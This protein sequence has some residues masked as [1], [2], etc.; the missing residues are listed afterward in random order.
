MKWRTALLVLIRSNLLVV[1]LFAYIVGNNHHLMVSLMDVLAT[2]HK[3]KVRKTP[4]SFIILS[5]DLAI[6]L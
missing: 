3:S 5:K 1:F 2:H 6:I 4:L